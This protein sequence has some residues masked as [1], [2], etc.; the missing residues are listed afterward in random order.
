LLSQLLLVEKLRLQHEL[1]DARQ[2]QLRLLPES[3]PS[4]RGFDIAGFSRP[5]REVGGD[6]FDYVSLGHGKTGI[7]LADVSGKGLKGAM[8]A[9]LTNG[10]LHEA[11]KDETSCGK[12]LSVLNEG[13]CPRTERQM[14]T[15]L[16]LAIL[17]ESGTTLKWAN[18]GQ[19]Y[20]TVK[21]G[22][23]V[24][25]FRSDS[26]LPLGMMPNVSYPDW[27]LELQSGDVILFYT[28]GIIEAENE[29]EEMY[30]A[31][32]LEKS[33][34]S[35]DSTM[36]AEKIIEAILQDVTHFVGSA[37]Q[38]DDMTVVVVKKL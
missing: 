15:A 31:E 2:M 5:A 11:A 4:V 3:A 24:F 32:R 23:Q 29:A 18:A 22:E 36:G 28:D 6:F 16:G 20:P 35:M 21:R 26:E 8:N 12:V 7:A 14:F 13:L 27:E 37:E 17:D 1:E 25:E 19:P 34:T 33:V 10:M 30:G 9:V 38:Y